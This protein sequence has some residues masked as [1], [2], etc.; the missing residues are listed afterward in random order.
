[1]CSPTALE[2]WW[3]EWLTYTLVPFIKWITRSFTLEQTKK[4]Q[5]RIRL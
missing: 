3:K 2:K 4:S 5:K 1:L